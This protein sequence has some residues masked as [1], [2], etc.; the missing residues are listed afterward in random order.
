VNSATQLN[1]KTQKTIFALLLIA[2]IA[3]CSP[4]GD[5]V[6]E[7]VYIGETEVSAILTD[8]PQ[9]SL[10][11]TGDLPTACHAFN[12][13]Y[14]IAIG[15]IDVTIFSTI[16][17]AATCIQGLS[18]FDETI[19]IPMTGQ[20]DGAYQIYLNGELVGEINLAGAAY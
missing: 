8:A 13:E 3:A 12:Y 6:R 19:E 1:M 18:P 14:E 5:L 15:R 16:S 11:I 4:T 10:H 2:A 7:P 20:P 17:P 9:I